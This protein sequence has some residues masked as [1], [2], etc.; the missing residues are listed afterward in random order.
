MAAAIEE[1]EYEGLDHQ[2]IAINMLAGAMAGISEHAVMYPVD[3]IKVSSLFT[4]HLV[5][6]R[7]LNNNNICSL[8]DSNASFK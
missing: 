8:P 6:F 1:I 4:S 2:G 5:G 7:R 3:S